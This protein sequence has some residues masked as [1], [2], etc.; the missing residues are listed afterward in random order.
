MISLLNNLSNLPEFSLGLE[1]WARLQ[2]LRKAVKLQD[3]N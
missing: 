1:L 2:I 3:V